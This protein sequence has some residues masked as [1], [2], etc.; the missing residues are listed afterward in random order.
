[1]FFLNAINES[2]NMGL[3]R[4]CTHVNISYVRYVGISDGFIINLGVVIA[5][6]FQNI[7]P[8]SFFFF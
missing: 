6:L 2:K 8:V 4:S 3:P 7:N 5:F 1:M